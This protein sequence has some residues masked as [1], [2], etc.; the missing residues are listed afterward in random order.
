M[1]DDELA[2]YRVRVIRIVEDSRERIREYG[3]RLLESDAVL[4]K[5]WKQPWQGAT[6]RRCSIKTTLPRFRIHKLMA[7]M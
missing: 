4:R 2:S 6:R 7:V 3:R 5:I 1:A